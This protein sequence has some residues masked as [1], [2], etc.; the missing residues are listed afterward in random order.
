MLSPL[1]DYPIHQVAEVI[2]HVGTS[3]RNFYDRYYFNLYSTAGD[4]FCVFGYGQYP[5]LGT[6]DA[7]VCVTDGLTHRVVR[8]SR[9]LGA[10]RMD[11]TVGPLRVEVVEPLRKLR[12]VG[13]AS[14]AATDAG[15]EI[16]ATFEGTIAPHLEPRHWRREF[17]RVTF[18]TQRLAQT[19]RWSGRLKLG[20]RSVDLDGDSW[21]GYRDRSW[22]VRPVGEQEP[23][24]IRGSRAPATFFWLYAPLQF[25]DHSYLIITQEDHDGSRILEEA[26]RVWNDGRL[27]QLGRPSHDIE[28]VPGTRAPKA[29]TLSMREPDGTPLE[30]HIETVLPC[31]L[32]VGSGYGP[33]PEWRHG[34][35]QGPLKVEGRTWDLTSP[36]VRKSLIGFAEY[37]ARAETS[38]GARGYGMFE[39]ACVGPHEQYGFTGWENLN[40]V[41]P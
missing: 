4:V 8:A 26:V 29:A 32:S 9:E 28:F 6:A 31:Y 24:G 17:D 38:T 22:G 1:D 39:F 10:D 34:M 3:D 15:V 18:D 33:D 7:F 5:N 21:W 14:D 30:I 35:W 37:S 23:P 11:T 16:D 25:S 12:V 36:E 13:E 20:D 2:R 27:D 40:L 19:G 41:V